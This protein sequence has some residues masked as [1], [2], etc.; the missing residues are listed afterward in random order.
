MKKLISI[1]LILLILL[2]VPSLVLANEL[3]Y[4][5]DAAGILNDD[6]VWVLNQRAMEISEEYMCDITIVTIDDMNYHDAYEFTK[7]IIEDYDMGYGPQKSIIMLFLSMEDRDY[8]L[9]AHG[10]GNTVFTDHGKDVIMDKHVLPLLAKDNY[11]DA[12]STFLDVSEDYFEQAREGSPFD[13]DTDPD[14][15][16]LSPTIKFGV[17]TLLP[18]LIAWAICGA[19]KRQMK[20]AVLASAAT[21]Y[22][23]KE[24]LNLTRQ[25]DS[26]LYRTESRRRIETKSSGGTSVDSSGYSGKSGKF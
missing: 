6:M 12:F 19:W 10:Y 23:S 5:T 7:T 8:A 16:K 9:V 4:V 18:L 21:N 20:T 22:I 26:F 11:Y 24:G 1:S 3:D 13:I 17:T 25:Q 2:M 14:Y 15:G